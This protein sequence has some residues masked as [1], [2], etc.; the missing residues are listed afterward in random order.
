MARLDRPEDLAAGGRQARE[1]RIGIPVAMALNHV[2]PRRI[3]I[4]EIV[5]EVARHGTGLRCKV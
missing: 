2:N 4:E 5:L 3:I 1:Q